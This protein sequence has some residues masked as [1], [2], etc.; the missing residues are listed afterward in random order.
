MASK[1]H[2]LDAAKSISICTLG[3]PRTEV[4]SEWRLQVERERY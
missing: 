2:A 4:C 1:P 3:M